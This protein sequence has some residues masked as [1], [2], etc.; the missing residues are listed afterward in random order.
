MCSHVCQGKKLI[1]SGDIII[2]KYNF[3]YKTLYLKKKLETQAVPCG[4]TGL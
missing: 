4:G 2:W 3:K 1:H